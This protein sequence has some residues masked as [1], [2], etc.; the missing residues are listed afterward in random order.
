MRK[1]VTGRSI[2]L[3]IILLKSCSPSDKG[4]PQPKGI[5]P[6][7]MVWIPGGTFNMGTADEMGWEEE[8]PVHKA[9]VNGFW[10]DVHEVTNEQFKNFVVS[11]GY[12]TDAEKAPSL[13]E[14]MSQVP[15]GTPPPDSADLV[16]GS[17]VFMIPE[18]AVPLNN[19]AHW[20]KWIH[21]ANWQHPEGPES[22]I[23]GREAHPVVHISWNDA[24]A[25]AKWIGKRLPT[26]AEW[27]F[28]ARGGLKNK[29]FVWGDEAPSD[30]KVFA[31]TWQGTFP[32]EN[33]AVDGFTGTAPVKSFAPNGYGLYDMAGNV[34]EWCN[35]WYDKHLYQAYDKDDVQDNP[36][37]PAKSHDPDQPYLPLRVQK[38]GSFLCHDSYCQRYRP[39]ARQSS[40]PESGMS[41]VGFR[42]VKDNSQK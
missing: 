1:F 10:M 28:A 9:K 2:V 3:L 39:G 8:K 37:G 4:S 13:E 27:E 21:G 42:C 34:W 17:M 41:H 26:E 20:W 40:S 31:N 11:T 16:P 6:E 18:Q 35:D 7:G 12:I 23:E 14:I 22:N 15:P 5:V 33:K 38:G 32:S 36:Q 30:T 24:Q 25:Y 19:Y 29:K